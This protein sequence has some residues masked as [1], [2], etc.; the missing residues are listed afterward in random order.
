VTDQELITA[1]RRGEAS[2]QKLLYDRYAPRLFGLCKRYLQREDAEDALMEGFF[3]IFTRIDQ[4][5]GSGNFEGWMRRIMV[6][7]ALMKIRKKHALKNAVE[8]DH[9][10]KDESF[11]IQQELEAEDILQLLDELP[12]GYRTVFNLYA[13]EGYK[14]REIAEML[15]I[16][17]NT[18][19][20]Q[21]ILARKKLRELLEKRARKESGIKK[22]DRP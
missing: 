19:K 3:K 7:Q 11:S 5:D 8:P 1:C 13:I 15:G 6:N 20:S 9:T 10:L 17:I 21:F 4:Y 16:S 14:H 22:Y 18:S 12:P 2:A